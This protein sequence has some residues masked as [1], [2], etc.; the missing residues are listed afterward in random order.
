MIFAP[1]IRIEILQFSGISLGGRTLGTPVYNNFD[2]EDL[3]GH[4]VVNLHCQ[5]RLANVS[6]DKH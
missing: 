6:C 2:L 5:L 3:Y 4:S 1:L